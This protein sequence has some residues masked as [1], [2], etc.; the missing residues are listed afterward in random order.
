MQ[1]VYGLVFGITEGWLNS[2]DGD[3]PGQQETEELERP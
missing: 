2:E 3:S 1:P